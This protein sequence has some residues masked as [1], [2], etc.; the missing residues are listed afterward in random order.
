MKRRPFWQA[1]ALCV[2]NTVVAEACTAGREWL[3]RAHTA[4]LVERKKIRGKER[5]R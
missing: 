5:A 2:A 3:E 1:L 4:A